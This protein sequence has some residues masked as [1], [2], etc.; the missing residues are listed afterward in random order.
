MP[1][2]R[3]WSAIVVALGAIALPARAGD[4]PAGPTT[5]DGRYSIA[6]LRA[7]VVYFVPSDREPLPDWRERI[8]W[9]CDRLRHFHAR[10]FAGRSRLVT[11]IHREPFRSTRT[12]AAVRS[13]DANA[14]FFRTMAEVDAA[15][16]PAV[17][18]GEAFPVLLVLS[19]VNWRPL[20][21]FSRLA[22][23][24]KGWRFDGAIA[25]DGVHVPGAAAGGSRAVYLP[26]RGRGWGLVSG[27][28]WRVPCRGS[29]CVLWHEGIGHAIGLPHPEAAD[30]S[31]MSQGQYRH[32]LAQSWIDPAQKAGLR[33]AP[34]T[35]APAPDPLFDRFTVVP[36][37][38][39]PRPRERVALRL[40]PRDL[41]PG[42][43]HVEVQTGLR[44]PWMT[45]PVDAAA[46]REGL[47]PLGSFD[48]PGGVAWRVR[49]GGPGAGAD[50]G[51]T[52]AAWGYFQ[53]RTEPGLAPPPGDVDATDREPVAESQPG[54]P[55]AAVDLLALVEP[56]RH[57][58]SGTWE[59]ID[60]D[61]LT[62][63]VAPRAYG[64]RIEIPYTPAEAYRLTVIAE[65]LDDPNGLT[66]GLRMGGRRFLALLGFG[67]TS[68]R[69]S[70]LE[71]VD[72]V[73]VAGNPTRV[74]GDVFVRGRPAEI[75]CTVRPGRVV[76]T[77]DGR[78]W[79]DWEGSPDRLSLGDY[80]R[81]P[82]DEALF[83]GAYDCRYR[84]LRVSLEALDGAGRP[85]DDA[86]N[87]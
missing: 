82:R 73:N 11:S 74:E 72:G 80:W 77:V 23:A 50:G 10:E 59:R 56:A 2:P 83:L 62:G 28:G 38:A 29:D 40:E 60:R 3:L 17:G 54:D 26:E 44:A 16:D 15:V 43:L 25:D 79:I 30:G 68:P 84:F 52:A 14:T 33:F 13:G 63:L 9:L 71:N 36:E 64:A 12:T 69:A 66:L 4:G 58:V 41:L 21:D 55:A 18:A 5:Q 75:V 34:P 86:G 42:D 27:D 67:E 47:V 6:T 19:D 57:G 8:E 65:P 7:T 53:V 76:V 1:H 45:I 22:P 85:L 35:E 39:S 48:R 51:A 81:T 24:G 49:G 20:D 87:R 78:P 46:I 32:A 70:A 61:G 31:V 37:P